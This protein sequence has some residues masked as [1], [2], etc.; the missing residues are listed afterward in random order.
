[1]TEQNIFDNKDITANSEQIA[2]LKKHFPNC[3]DKK[4]NFLIDSFKEILKSDDINTSHEGYTLDWLGKSYARLL[5]NERPRTLIRPNKEHNVKEQNKNSNNLLI[6]GDNLEVL[7]HLKNAYTESVKVIY[8][9]PPYNTGSDGFVYKDD[10]KFTKEE[11]ANLANVSEEEAQRILDFTDKGSNSHSAWLTFIYPRLYITRDLLREDG[12]IFISID[13]NEQAQLKL[14]CDEVFGEENFVD[15]ITWNTRVPKNDNKGLGNIHQ[16]ILVYVKKQLNHQF[17][18]GKDGLDEV[19]EL[20]N[21]MKEQKTPIPIAE[22]ELK[23][24]Y[25]KKGLDRGITLYNALDDNYEP[26]GKINMSWPN[27]DTFGP[28]YDVFHPKTKKTTK[29]PDRGWRW[30]QKTFNKNLDYNNVNQRHDGSYICGQIWFAKDENTQPSSIRYLRDV[31]KMLLRTIISLKSDGGVDLEELFGAKSIFSNPK[32]TALVTL[33]LNSIEDKESLI[34]DFFAGSGTT[35]HAVMNLNAEDE[36]NRQYI[37]IQLPEETDKKSEANREGYKTI[38][39]I[40]KARIEKASEKIAIDYPNYNGDLG[41]K[42]FGT[43]PLPQYYDEDIDELSSDTQTKI[44]DGS[45]VAESELEAILTTWSLYDRILLT[46]D[47][48]PVI[49]DDYK[50][51]YGKGKESNTLYLMNKGFNIDHIKLIIDKL[52]NDKEFTPKKIVLYGH[53]FETKPQRELSEALNSFRNKKQLEID[54]IKR[55]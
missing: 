2:V 8:I 23:N 48:E 45:D 54:I 53:N 5:A 1:M 30:N 50:A 33:L 28:T 42:I 6:K 25:S 46:T 29:K 36:G 21:K 38:F 11:L 47:L 44:W 49:F 9:D 31:D 26:W 15:C 27:S 37:M 39:D 13:N 20:L 51:Y 40:T 19:F 7:K 32:P 34:L 55:Y 14:L 41:F 24:F 10:R 43:T 12:V 52:E 3:F 22:E 35:A 4:G 18:M 16:Y 17:F